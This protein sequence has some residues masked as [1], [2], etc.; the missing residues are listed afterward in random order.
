MKKDCTQVIWGTCTYTG[1]TRL[2]CPPK[3]GVGAFFAYLR[4]Y[5]ALPLSLASVQPWLWAVLLLLAP[6]ACSFCNP[7]NRSTQIYG[8]L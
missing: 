7:V 3:I 6:T 8:G 1:M 5:L 4:L 2:G